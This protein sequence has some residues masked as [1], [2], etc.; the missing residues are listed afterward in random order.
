MDI[1]IRAPTETDLADLF[2]IRCDPLVKPH[3]YKLSRRET[4][5]LWNEQLFGDR[6]NSRLEFKCTT[7][8]R[9]SEVIGH[10]SQLHYEV[11][12][13]RTCYCGWNLAPP[14]WGQGIAMIALS[15]L[16]DRFFGD[17]Q[18]DSV[19]SD[20]FASNQRCIRVLQ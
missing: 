1:A 4:I 9:H 15:D 8:V 20:C 3:Q 14:Y 12:G 13:Q 7:I 6:R 16:F 10:I 18:I 2:R 11:N 17:Q 19:I 5:K